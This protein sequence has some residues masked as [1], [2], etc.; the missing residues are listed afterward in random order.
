MPMSNYILREDLDIEA[1]EVS[2][3]IFRVNWTK[4][5]RGNLVG[6]KYCEVFSDSCLKTEKR[7]KKGFVNTMVRLSHLIL[8][9]LT[10][11]LSPFFL[12]KGY[13]LMTGVTPEE[14]ARL[15]EKIFVGTAI[16]VKSEWNEKHTYIYSYVTIS[17]ERCVKG[18]GEREVVIK[19][20]GGVVGEIG[21]KVSNAPKFRIGE[22]AVLFLKPGRLEVM[23]GRQGKVTIKNGAVARS[24]TPIQDFIN[25]IERSIQDNRSQTDL[26]TDLP[27]NINEDSY[28]FCIT[29]IDWTYQDNPMAEP[30]YVN[31]NAPDITDELHAVTNAAD[32]WSLCGACFS[33]FYGGTISTA[34]TAFDGINLVF[35]GTDLSPTTL[36]QTTYWYDTLTGDCLEC[37]MEFNNNYTWHTDG[38]DYDVETVALHEFGHYLVLCHSN[39]PDAVMYPNYKGLDRDLH[40]DD[41][42]A[43]RSIYGSCTWGEVSITDAYVTDAEGIRKTEFCPKQP[44]QFHIIYDV[45]GGTNTLYKV[46]GTIKVFGRI[47]YK[48]Q[49]R[50]PGTG[51]HMVKSRQDG[52]VIQV[53]KTAAGKTKTIIYKLKLK[54]GGVFLDKDKTKSQIA[55]LPVPPVAQ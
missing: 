6:G 26:L 35:W 29:G 23:A 38:D 17:I 2:N 51:Y 24:G 50:Y 54:D 3:L 42:E 28:P 25:A 40:Q 9:T 20:P 21:Q 55:V 5:S 22:R 32:T 11:L 46:K 37:D 8:L 34:E 53:P 13:P 7:I 1:R 15:A 10:F 14:L 31:A 4:H 27:Q 45:L 43:I 49:F 30:Y 18:S 47:Y 36:A 33:F 48:K 41:V 39:N 12:G 19:V 52:R 44:I 16:E